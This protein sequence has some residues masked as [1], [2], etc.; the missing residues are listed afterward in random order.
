[1]PLLINLVDIPAEGHSIEC[2]VQSSDVALSPEDGEI[3]GTLNCTGQVFSSDD[4]SAN[5]QGMIT[6]KVVREC[7]RCLIQYTDDLSLSWDAQFRNPSQS[8]IV[9]APSRKN[10]G[11]RRHDSTA[12][13]E[14]EEEIDSYPIIDKQIDLLP[15]LREHLILATP[16]Q[17]LCHESCAGLC[18][19]CGTNLNE[20]VCGCC[21]PV[22]DTSE[23][24]STMSS[25]LSRITTKQPSRTV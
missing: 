19:I 22:A 16:L 17:P 15:A 3:L 7:V 1:M 10:S 9:R 11:R 13:D 14:H 21:S 23:A 6:G 25:G 18:Q 2:K 24:I 20:G 5:F 8:T 4:H 12:D